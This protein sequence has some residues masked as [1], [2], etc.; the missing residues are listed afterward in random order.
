M[1][2]YACM[3]AHLHKPLC[4]SVQRYKQ[5]DVGVVNCEE[6]FWR[7]QFNDPICVHVRSWESSVIQKV[8]RQVVQV[9]NDCS[10]QT[11]SCYRFCVS[12]EWQL[13]SRQAFGKLQAPPLKL[14]YRYLASLRKTSPEQGLW[15]WES[16]AVKYWHMSSRLTENSG[17]SLKWKKN[18]KDGKRMTKHL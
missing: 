11:H 5:R 15:A 10:P 18:E 2:V 12:I 6:V 13:P 14:W 16:L 3:R 17:K 4:A 1:L 9:S 7:F 8:Q